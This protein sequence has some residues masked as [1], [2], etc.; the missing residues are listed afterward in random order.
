MSYP[1]PAVTNIVTYTYDTAGLL[2][3]YQKRWTGQ[4]GMGTE[5]VRRRLCRHKLRNIW[6]CLGMHTVRLINLYRLHS[7]ILLAG[8]AV[9]ICTLGTLTHINLYQ[10]QPRHIISIPMAFVIT[11]SNNC[12]LP[13][14][15]RR[16]ACT[17]YFTAFGIVATCTIGPIKSLGCNHNNSIY[18]HGS[19]SMLRLLIFGH[20]CAKACRCFCFLAW[21]IFAAHI[22]V[23]Q[24]KLG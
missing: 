10:R 11:N 18:G 12:H 21:H 16:P 24:G 19:L 6:N 20:T 8:Q 4:P 5:V 2:N 9:L 3:N 15:N 14:L 23:S 17:R 1:D 22:A 13:D 7:C